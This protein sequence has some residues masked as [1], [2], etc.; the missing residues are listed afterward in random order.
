MIRLIGER[1]LL[2]THNEL[3]IMSCKEEMK[4]HIPNGNFALLYYI[5]I[6]KTDIDFPV[7]EFPCKTT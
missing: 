6:A 3:D 5:V 7:N 1:C 4:K 2:V